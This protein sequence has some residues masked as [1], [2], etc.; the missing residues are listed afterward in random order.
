MSNFASRTRYQSFPGEED[1]RFDAELLNLDPDAR[2]NLTKYY[3]IEFP[4]ILVG[5]R[6]RLLD[7]RSGTVL[8]CKRRFMRAAI[9]DISLTDR[10][11][12]EQVV[13]NRKGK[14]NRKKYMDF[15]LLSKEF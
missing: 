13:L 14:K 8:S 7:G 1:P 3:S 15:E 10:N 9:F 12:T 6:V 2:K 11:S 4:E 5:W